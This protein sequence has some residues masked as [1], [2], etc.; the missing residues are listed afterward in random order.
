MT[1]AAEGMV[2]ASV[3][4]S[5]TRKT[6]INTLLRLG[7]ERGEVILH[8][9]ALTP[10][11][12]RNTFSRIFTAYEAAKRSPRHAPATDPISELERLAQLKDAGLI[13]EEEFQTAREKYVRKLT[14]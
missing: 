11:Q 4:N 14:E 10:L 9:G 5:L 7:T 13:T 6:T 2:V 12:L 3:L 8:H 1:G